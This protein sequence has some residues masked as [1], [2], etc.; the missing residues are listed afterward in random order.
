MPFSQRTRSSPLTTSL[1]RHPKS[2]TPHPCR[3]ACNSSSTEPLLT[4]PKRNTVSAP[5]YSPVTACSPNFFEREMV[6]IGSNRN[7]TPD[8]SSADVIFSSD[9][10]FAGDVHLKLFRRL[11]RLL[12]LAL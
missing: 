12:P 7:R 1:P 5:A 6:D 9:V 4:E 2:K 10:N 3:S 11:L 8:Y